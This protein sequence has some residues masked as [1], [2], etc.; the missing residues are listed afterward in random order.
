MGVDQERKAA[1]SLIGTETQGTLKPDGTLELDEKPNL[2]AERV[3]VLLRQ[4]PDEIP[5]NKKAF[6]LGMEAM[7]AIATKAE[8][9]PDGGVGTLAD[10]GMSREEWDQRQAGLEEIQ[11]ECER[12]GK[13]PWK[14]NSDRIF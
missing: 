2:P 9:L 1:M 10:V 7:W 13:R 4:Q 8:T 14:R 6:W 12:A 11:D 3:K 5:A